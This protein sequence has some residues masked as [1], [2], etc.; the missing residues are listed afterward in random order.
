ML[1]RLVSLYSRTKGNLVNLDL[2]KPEHFLP[3]QGHGYADVRV[4]SISSESFYASDHRIQRGLQTTRAGQMFRVAGSLDFEEIAGILPKK[5]VRT[6]FSDFIRNAFANVTMD[7]SR[8]KTD[9][10]S[11]IPLELRE[12]AVA[13]A[14]K[15]HQFRFQ[16]EIRFVSFTNTLGL[17]RERFEKNFFVRLESRMEGKNGLIELRRF[18][19]DPTL[20]RLEVELASMEEQLN[21]LYH[22]QPSEALTTVA[23]LHPT[24]AGVLIH[25]V[26]GHRSE[27]SGSSNDNSGL[28]VGDKIASEQ[29]NVDDLPS[30]VEQAKFYSFDDEGVTSRNIRV[31]DHGIFKEAFYFLKSAF[32][33]GIPPNGRGTARDFRY[34]PIPRMTNLRIAPGNI[35]PEELIRDLK[36]GVILTGTLG[37][38]AG[39]RSFHIQC[40]FGRL[41]KN[42]KPSN[43]ILHP[44]IGGDS[45]KILEAIDF[46]GNDFIWIEDGGCLSDNQFLPFSGR[47]SPHIRLLNLSIG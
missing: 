9:M 47:G 44:V 17:K 8:P 35:P 28:T 33:K 31:V 14:N 4:E 22:A 10:L 36:H 23:V 40:Q 5:T 38:I 29:L 11:P 43:Y 41:I 20:S 3:L 27:L 15:C 21:E 37:A 30:K 12:F 16:N 19:Q 26:I 45:Q 18:I 42:G 13:N 34:R 24:V 46:V 32:A 39:A 7:P 2:D 6:P 1:L 25:E